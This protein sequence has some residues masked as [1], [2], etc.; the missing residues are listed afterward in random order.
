MTLPIIQ[1]GLRRSRW[2][3]LIGLMLFVALLAVLVFAVVQGVSG[4]R[5]A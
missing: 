1:K 5:S 3:N 2:V 4:L